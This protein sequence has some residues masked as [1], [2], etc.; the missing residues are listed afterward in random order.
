[1]VSNYLDNYSPRL[2]C[3]ETFVLLIGSF[4]SLLEESENCKPQMR[5]NQVWTHAALILLLL[6]TDELQRLHSHCLCKMLGKNEL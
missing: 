1:M 3:K 5:R 4:S 6:R 2:T